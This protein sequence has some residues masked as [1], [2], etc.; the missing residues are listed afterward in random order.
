LPINIVT[1]FRSRRTSHDE[2]E[3]SL[4]A[5]RSGHRRCRTAGG[6]RGYGDEAIGTFRSVRHQPSQRLALFRR[7][8]RRYV[9]GDCRRRLAAEDG[10]RQVLR[11]VQLRAYG[12]RRVVPDVFQFH[13]PGCGVRRPNIGLHSHTELDVLQS[14]VLLPLSRST[15][16]RARPRLEAI[17]SAAVGLAG[18]EDHWVR[19]HDLGQ[20]SFHIGRIQEDV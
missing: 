15:V 9:A 11:A 17:L 7:D 8:Q 13:P 5:P 19:S 16:S 14:T 2:I 6:R 1:C 20:Q 4:P 18:R 12:V 3:R 10:V